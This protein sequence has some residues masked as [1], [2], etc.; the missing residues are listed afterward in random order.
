MEWYWRVRTLSVTPIGSRGPNT[1]VEFQIGTPRRSPSSTRIHSS[2]AVSRFTITI[3]K[4]LEVGGRRNRIDPRVTTHRQRECNKGQAPTKPLQ[5]CDQGYKRC[6]NIMNREVVVDQQEQPSRRSPMMACPSSPPPDAI[7]TM[8]RILNDPPAAPRK[9]RAPPKPRPLQTFSDV[10]P[11]VLLA[12]PLD[13]GDGEE[14]GPCESMMLISSSSSTSSTL[15]WDA[16]SSNNGR[17]NRL[18]HHHNNMVVAPAPRKLL[19]HRHESQPSLFSTTSNPIRFAR[20]L[21]RSQSEHPFLSPPADHCCD[22]EEDRQGS[23]RHLLDHLDRPSPPE[24][25]RI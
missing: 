5:S 12:W 24:S 15:S 25:P 1:T 13:Y 16:T 14:E 4:G 19:F 18:S 8:E 3:S 10:P 2:L 21:A 20:P 22:E 6:N 9:R 7:W 23:T 11:S 17:R